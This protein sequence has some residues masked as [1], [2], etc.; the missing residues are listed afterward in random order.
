MSGTEQFFY[1]VGVGVCAAIGIAL[2]GGLFAFG[3]A[4]AKTL[5]DIGGGDE[6]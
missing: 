4:L 6:R 2:A 3:K 5:F 1:Y